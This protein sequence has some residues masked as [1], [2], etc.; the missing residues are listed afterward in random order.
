MSNFEFNK[1]LAAVLC[2]G[3]V[4][5]LAGFISKE[6][7]P[8][9]KLEKDAVFV[10]GASSEAHAAIP[11]APEHAEPVLA[12]IAS[13]DVAKGAKLSKA[14]AACHSFE[15]GGPIKIGPDLWNV[16]GRERAT[17]PGFDYSDGMKAKGGHWTLETLN[18]FLWK[19]K[20]FIDGTKMN[21]AGL[22]KTQDRADL[23]AWLRQQADSPVPDPSAEDIAAEE[24]EYGPKEEPATND[25]ASTPA[26]GTQEAAAPSEGNAP[27]QD[28]T[29]A[30]ETQETAPAKE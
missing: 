1:I 2:A 13:A 17:F 21:F 14:C 22:K 30:A 9:E 16:V 5:M 12:L 29:P 11:K 19:P 24:A 27:K 6:V 7:V 4:A 10:E 26:E 25:A 23:L 20:K 8:S 28:A 15:K 18:Q 3:I